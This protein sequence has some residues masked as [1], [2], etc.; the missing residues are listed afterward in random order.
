[1][2]PMRLLYIYVLKYSIYCIRNTDNASEYKNWRVLFVV[3]KK[4]KFF[5]YFLQYYGRV[6]RM[7]NQILEKACIVCQA[8]CVIPFRIHTPCTCPKLHKL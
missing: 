5:I 1:M 7:Q 3:D 8:L 2:R 4:M 6:K